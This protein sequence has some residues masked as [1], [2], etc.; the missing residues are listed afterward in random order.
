[1]YEKAS[2]F[3]EVIPTVEITDE[4]HVTLTFLTAPSADEYVVVVISGAGGGGGGGVGPW[5][6]LVLGEDWEAGAYNVPAVRTENGGAIA[7]LRGVIVVAAGHTA[8]A[9]AEIATLGAS[10][11]PPKDVFVP[12]LNLNLASLTY[13]PILTTGKMEIGTTMTEGQQLAT[14]GVTWSLT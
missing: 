10:A 4:N 12:T 13:I 5:E 11:R 3:A 1:V 7:R 2:P 8:T 9:G 6:P 14:D